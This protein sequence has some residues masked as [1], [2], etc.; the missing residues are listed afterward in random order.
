MEYVPS[1]ESNPL[2]NPTLA[3]TSGSNLGVARIDK[4]RIEMNTNALNR[5]IL[6][7][8]LIA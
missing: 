6:N 8:M 5:N 4:M 2:I 3:S 1:S 7:E